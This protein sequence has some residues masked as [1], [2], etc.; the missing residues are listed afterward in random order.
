MSAEQQKWVYSRKGGGVTRVPGGLRKRKANKVLRTRKK[1]T[2]LELEKA[3][4]LG[5]SR[6][7]LRRPPGS[8]PSY[9]LRL[10][11]THTHTHTL[12]YIHTSSLVHTVVYFTRRFFAAVKRGRQIFSLT[13]VLF[14]A[15]VNCSLCPI[16]RL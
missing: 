9:V 4:Y 7:L 1:N 15:Q 10:L 8:G 11:D 12:V 13:S 16:L 5:L 6:C 3:K 14:Y 2:S